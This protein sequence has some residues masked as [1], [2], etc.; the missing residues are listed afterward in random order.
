MGLGWHSPTGGSGSRASQGANGWTPENVALLLGSFGTIISQ[1]DR[2]A[3]VLESGSPP[4]DVVPDCVLVTESG[5]YLVD[6]AGNYVLQDCE[7]V[8][9]VLVNEAGA[10]VVSESGATVVALKPQSLVTSTGAPL[11]N[12]EGLQIVTEVL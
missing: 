5:E 7:V 4:V 1:L 2:I 8:E 10:Y 9:G 6:E 11:V 12:N 3:T